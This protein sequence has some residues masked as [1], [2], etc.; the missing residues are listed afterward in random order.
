MTKNNKSTPPPA[1]EWSFMVDAEK[2]ETKPKHFS[3][4]PN[5]AEL[6][7][8]A[9][10]MGVVEIKSLESE[11]D[12]V[13]EGNK[14]IIHV[15]GR[16]KAAVRQ[17]CVVTGKPVNSD[18]TE[19]FEGWFTD[20]SKTLSFVK[21]RQEK[22]AVKAG[23]EFPILPEN[24]DPEPIIDGQIDAGELTAQYLSLA[25]DPYPRAENSHYDNG[26]DAP[27]PASR[28]DNPFAALKEWRDNNKSE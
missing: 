28:P 12:F 24:E 7:A 4:K 6:K 21:A 15:T 13:R 3:I 9:R 23:V 27:K 10:R 26:D 5:S 22:Q 25:I 18:I 17:E 2:I 16:L 19:D 1:P 8:L 20:K 11:L 14:A